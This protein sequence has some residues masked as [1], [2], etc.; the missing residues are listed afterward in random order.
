MGARKVEQE[1]LGLIVELLKTLSLKVVADKWDVRVETISKFLTKNQTSHRA[2]LDAHR[3]PIIKLALSRK[4][5][6]SITAF[7]LGLTKAHFYR[8]RKALLAGDKFDYWQ[9]IS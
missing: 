4:E 9:S 7:N 6:A 8:V 2:I 3:L 5:L 1:D